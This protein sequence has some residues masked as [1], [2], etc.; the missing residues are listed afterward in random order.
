MLIVRINILKFFLS[1]TQKAKFGGHMYVVF[2]TMPSQGRMVRLNV[3]FEMFGESMI[4][5]ESVHRLSIVV[6]SYIKKKNLE[7]AYLF[8]GESSRTGVWWAL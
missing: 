1:L 2:I 8:S 3:H 5:Q 7:C 4:F 6:V